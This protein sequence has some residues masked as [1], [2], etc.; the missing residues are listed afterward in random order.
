MLAILGTVE[1]EARQRGPPQMVEAAVRA[2][3]MSSGGHVLGLG[4]PPLKKIWTNQRHTFKIFSISIRRSYMSELIRE[5]VTTLHR[6]QDS[7]REFDFLGI[8]IVAHLKALMKGNVISDEDLAIIH[9][10]YTLKTLGL[11]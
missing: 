11:A 5:T 7:V 8:S 6:P 10:A 9:H 1:I 3:R 2:S 4:L